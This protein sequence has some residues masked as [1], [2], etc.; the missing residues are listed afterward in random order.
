MVGNTRIKDWKKGDVLWFDWYNVP[1]GTA[2]LGRKNRLML[3]ITGENTPAF[4][5][6]IKK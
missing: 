6:L 4:E 1:H 3:V 2:N 5:K